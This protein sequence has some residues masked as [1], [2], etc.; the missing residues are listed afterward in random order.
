MEGMNIDIAQMVS[1][2][3]FP[4]VV[5]AWHM[6]RTDKKMDRMLEILTILAD[7]SKINTDDNGGS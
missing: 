5:A 7:R 6:L 3:G 2:V 1:Q 4:I